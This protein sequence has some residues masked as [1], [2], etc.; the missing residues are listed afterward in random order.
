MKSG[1]NASILNLFNFED[2]KISNFVNQDPE[3]YSFV[4][5]SKIKK[6]IKN[7]KLLKNNGY[8]K[9]LFTFLSLKIFMDRFSK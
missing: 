4:D 8:S 2:K 1:F 6:L 3:L 5:K 7:K 9:F